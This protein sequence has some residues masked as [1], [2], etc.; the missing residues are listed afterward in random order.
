MHLLKTSGVCSRHTCLGSGCSFK[1][2]EAKSPWSQKGIEP[3]PQKSTWEDY[4]IRLDVLTRPAQGEDAPALDLV[5]S[6]A[7]P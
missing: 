7:E 4:G 5:L 3:P 2:R 1:G 6:W